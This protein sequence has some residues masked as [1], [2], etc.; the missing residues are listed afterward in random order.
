MTQGLTGAIINENYSYQTPT[1]G[2]TVVLAN[3]DWNVVINPATTLAALTVQMCADPFDGQIVDIKFQRAII[4]LTISPNTGQSVGA[5]APATMVAGKTFQAIYRLATTTWYISYDDATFDNVVTLTDGATPALDASAGGQFI[6]SA[7]GDR[8]IAQ[9]TNPVNGQK[10]I[11]RHFASGG[12]RTL[13]LNTG[14]G[15]FRFGSDITA[16]TQTVSGKTDYIG[17]IYNA[18]DNKWDVVAYSKGY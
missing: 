8:T 9:P 18:T 5:N 11:I 12:A 10:I 13:S 17:C 1:T 2:G 7:A 16:L 6:L 14:T 3:S 4:A 15:G